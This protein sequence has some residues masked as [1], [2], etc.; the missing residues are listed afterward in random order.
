MKVYVNWREFEIDID[1]IESISFDYDSKKH[2][3]KVHLNGWSEDEEF[4]ISE[5]K[6]EAI[7]EFL[8]WLSKESKKLSIPGSEG[9]FERT[10]AKESSSVGPGVEETLALDHD[11][12][13]FDRAL[14]KEVSRD[15]PIPA[16]P[17]TDP[18][19]KDI[20]YRW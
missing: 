9:T 12:E 19:G 11:E 10:I 17:W 15:G 3:W 2:K 6:G 8:K 13:N 1:K 7:I 20:F 5:K 18:E 16:E 14:S 4:E